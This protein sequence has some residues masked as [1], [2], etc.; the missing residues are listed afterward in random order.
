MMESIN[1]ILVFRVGLLGDTVVAIPS[2]H[3]LR[4][5]FPHAHITLM[6]ERPSKKHVQVEQL[7]D[8]SGLVDDYLTYPVLKGNRRRLAAL[9]EIVKLLLRIR[10]RNYD[11]LVHL[12]P[13]FRT[14]RRD[15]K[16]LG[17]RTARQDA[18]DRLFFR[19]AGISKQILTSP[20]RP[21]KPEQHPLPVMPQEADFFLFCLGQAGLR[22]PEAGHGV[23]DLHLGPAEDLEVAQWELKT[24]L[25]GDKRLRV[26]FG[27]GSN[28]A[29][30]RWPLERYLVVAK[31]LVSE[32][33][34]MPVAFGGSEDAVAAEQ[35]ISACGRG[36]N[37]CGKLGIRGAIRALRDCRLF[38]GNDTGTMHM[39]AAAGVPC[40]AI[41]SARNPPGKWFPYGTGHRVHRVAVS[42]EGCNLDVCE[43][44][45]LRCLTAICP[46]EVIASCEEV[47]RDCLRKAA[48]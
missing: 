43:H 23:M 30:T 21:H 12:A 28:R 45:H 44:E 2:L 26:G 18:R 41:F 19:L 42:C 39:A 48:G 33:D 11:L 6:H 24:G 47:L 31:H 16:E 4:Q 29:T 46:E 15:A 25:T 38:V 37:A 14:L 1:R 20:H 10:C 32:W 5:N 9:A 36:A 8:G 3:V 27:L 13:G 22:V 40:V 17:V 34:V 35:L 7:L